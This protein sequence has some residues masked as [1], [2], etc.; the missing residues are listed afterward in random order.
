[1]IGRCVESCKRIVMRKN[2][3]NWECRP[4]SRNNIVDR[5]ISNVMLLLES[6][7]E[8]DENVL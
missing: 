3:E 5:P 1:M 7:E 6:E 8:V 2:I 4:S